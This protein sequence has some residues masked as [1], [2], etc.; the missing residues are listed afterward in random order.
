MMNNKII[1]DPLYSLD[2]ALEDGRITA[3]YNENRP[4]FDLRG[5]SKRE[6]ELGRPLADEEIIE[7]IVR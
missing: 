4:V 7:Y 6:K 2:L 5:I 3:D 1:N